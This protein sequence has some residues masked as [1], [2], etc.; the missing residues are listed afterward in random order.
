[1]R[2]NFTVAETPVSL[3]ATVNNILDQRAWKVLAA[4]TFQLDDVRR[5]NL[6][7]IADF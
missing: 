2:H 1:V 5:F 7:L 6:F 3:R 4:N